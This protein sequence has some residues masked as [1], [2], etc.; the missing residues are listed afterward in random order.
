MGFKKK[1][2]Q[3]F[4]LKRDKRP[5]DLCSN[6][7]LHYFLF[8]HAR[9][10]EPQLTI[11]CEGGC[12]LVG[13]RRTNLVDEA[14]TTAGRTRP[15][16]RPDINQILKW[17]WSPGSMQGKKAYT[18]I[19]QSKDNKHRFHALLYN[20][21]GSWY[22]AVYDHDR[23]P[24]MPKMENSKRTAAYRAQTQILRFVRKAIKRAEATK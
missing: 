2:L 23:K 19:I 15:A 16:P 1:A 13:D 18:A 5:C 7:E 20:S 11:Q 22:W 14:Y 9:H 24:M 12:T 10:P 6:F 8:K 3:H 4:A 17:K 21:N